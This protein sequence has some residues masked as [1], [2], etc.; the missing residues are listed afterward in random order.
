MKPRKRPCPRGISRHL[1]KPQES[2][3]MRFFVAAVVALGIMTIDF[4]AYDNSQRS[5]L[6]GAAAQAENKVQSTQRS[7]GKEDAV[8]RLETNDV[9]VSEAV[10]QATERVQELPK[11]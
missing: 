9:S 2:L 6:T 8:T 7:I 10:P 5:I 4:R 1:T 3:K 11:K